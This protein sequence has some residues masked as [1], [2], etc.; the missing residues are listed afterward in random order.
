M[1][2]LAI[3]KTVNF[4]KEP[5]R[6]SENELRKRSPAIH[7]TVTFC[8]KPGASGNE[9]REGSMD[10]LSRMQRTQEI[11]KCKQFFM[12]AACVKTASSFLGVSGVISAFHVSK[13]GGI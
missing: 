3:H 2:A 6:S 7:K 9:L 10:T 8:K 12:S 1:M 11:E 4:C 13:H 5:G